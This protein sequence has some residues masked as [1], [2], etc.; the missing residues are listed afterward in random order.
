MFTHSLYW[1]QLQHCKMDT[2]MVRVL[3]WKPIRIWWSDRFERDLFTCWPFDLTRNPN[4][5]I[6]YTEVKHSVSFFFPL[7]LLLIWSFDWRETWRML[8]LFLVLF[9]FVTILIFISVF[10]FSQRVSKIRTRNWLWT[11]CLPSAWWRIKRTTWRVISGTTCTT[12]GHFT[13]TRRSKSSKGIGVQSKWKS[14]FFVLSFFSALHALFIEE[15]TRTNEPKKKPVLYLCVC[16]GCHSFSVRCGLVLKTGP[17]W[18]VLSLFATPC[19]RDL[20][21]MCLFYIK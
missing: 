17:V 11:S 1:V 16:H 2:P 15:R 6:D 19:E 14:F 20:L 8:L 3:W 5:L 7:F 9:F 21:I 4:S 18:H 13:R 10:L 12:T